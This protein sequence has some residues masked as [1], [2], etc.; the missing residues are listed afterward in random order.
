MEDKYTDKDG[1]I[2]DNVHE[3]W[4]NEYNHMSFRTQ[5][6]YNEYLRKLQESQSK[7]IQS[8]TSKFE[9]SYNF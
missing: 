9:E 7:Q 4:F 1:K 6:A 8:L 2:V 5:S 3:K